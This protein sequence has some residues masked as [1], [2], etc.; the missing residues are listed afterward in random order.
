MLEIKY[1]R[2]NLSTVRKALQD[3]GHR[4]D[5]ADF[6]KWDDER[7]AVLQEIEAL[8]HERNVVSDRIDFFHPLK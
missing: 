5:L 7:S 2:Q 8:R 3:R 6:E 4:V 1:L